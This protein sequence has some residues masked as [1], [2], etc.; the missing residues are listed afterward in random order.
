[1]RLQRNKSLTGDLE[2]GRLITFNIWFNPSV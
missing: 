2:E 1:L